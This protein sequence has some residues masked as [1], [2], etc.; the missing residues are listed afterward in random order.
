MSNVVPDL[1]WAEVDARF[2]SLQAGRTLDAKIQQIASTPVIP[3]TSIELSGG[4][5]KGPMEKNKATAYLVELAHAAGQELGIN[6]Q[7]VQTGGTSDGNFTGELGIP[8][9]DGLGPI[10]GLDH[11]PGEFL[12]SESIVSRT[13]MLAGLIQ[14]IA[15]HHLNL[16]ELL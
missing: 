10:G 12:E 15:H 9:L 1:A 2:A 3:G 5:Q 11:S 7:D 16:K 14:A 4:I 13:A 6:F 8:T